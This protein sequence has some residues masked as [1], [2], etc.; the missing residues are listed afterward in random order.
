[1]LAP[2]VCAHRCAHVQAGALREARDKGLP[3]EVV[4][5][6]AGL[7]REYVPTSTTTLHACP[8]CTSQYTS[9]LAAA[10]CCDPC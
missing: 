7:T 6:S 3:V 10:E 5:I 4:R 1:M 2:L 9:P 8:G